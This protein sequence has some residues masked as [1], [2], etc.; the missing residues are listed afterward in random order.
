MGFTQEEIDKINM[1][2]KMRPDPE[3]VREDIE[4]LIRI[5]VSNFI[6]ISLKGDLTNT[7]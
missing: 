3:A 5:L 6:S 7:V 1:E 4:E 2:I